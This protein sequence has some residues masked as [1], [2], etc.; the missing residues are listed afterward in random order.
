[1]DYEKLK[2]EIGAIVKIAESVP[3]NLQVKCFEI[4][5]NRFLSPIASQHDVVGLSGVGRVTGADSDDS[6]LPIS[7]QMKAFM[8]MTGVT[9]ANLSRILTYDNGEVHFSA[10]PSTRTTSHGVVQWALLTALRNALTKG[11]LRVDPEELRSIC[12]EKG[13]YDGGNFWGTLKSTKHSPLFA[14]MLES[15]GDARILTPKGKS[16]LGELIQQLAGR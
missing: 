13:Y 5:L 14:G 4:L 2:T 11:D 3:E 9:E 7:P 12:Q 1:M 10:E 15:Q 6:D 16:A 8:R